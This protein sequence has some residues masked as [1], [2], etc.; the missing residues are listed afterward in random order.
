MRD[1]KNRVGTS[2]IFAIFLVFACVR[3]RTQSSADAP[4]AADAAQDS[5][6]SLED[7]NMKGGD[8]AMPPFSDSV[9]DV[10]SAVRR[11]L[12]SKGIA[13][14][15]INQGQCAQNTLRAP[16]SADQ[17]VFVGDHPFQT[18]MSNPILTP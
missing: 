13:L 10:N 8:A 2:I 14:R 15:V 5:G 16:A 1:S 17:Q 6:R 4:K 11:P 18:T 3:G 7:L 9:V 12:L